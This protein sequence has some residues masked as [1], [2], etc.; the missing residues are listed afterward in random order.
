[1]TIYDTYFD[2]THGA[3]DTALDTFVYQRNTELSLNHS[4]LN[5]HWDIHGTVV[6]RWTAGQQQVDRSILHLGHDS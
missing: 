6:V 5:L 1:M 4:L 2:I 3:D